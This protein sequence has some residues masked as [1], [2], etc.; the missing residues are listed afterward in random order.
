M[1]K[2]RHHPATSSSKK[3]V[4]LLFPHVH[5]MPVPCSLLLED[6]KKAVPKHLYDLGASLLACGDVA[7][8][9]VD[10][11]ER[12]KNVVYSYFV[13]SEL[14]STK[15]YLVKIHRQED[16][17]VDSVC[18]CYATHNKRKCCLSSSQ[19][20]LSSTTKS[21]QLHQNCSD[22]RIWGSS[23]M[24]V[25]PWKKKLIMILIGRGL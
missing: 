17:F 6:I 19:S 15:W 1:K 3:R 20:T 7:G 22:K 5:V 9:S 11:H 8:F 25:I 12:S 24:Q 13:H 2:S 10:L 21:Y 14:T 16:F 18:T 4:S 23:R